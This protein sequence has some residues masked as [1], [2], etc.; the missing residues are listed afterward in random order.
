ML[1]TVVESSA[2]THTYSYSTN[3]LLFTKYCASDDDFTFSSFARLLNI[4]TVTI[5]IVLFARVS[6]IKRFQ[7]VFKHQPRKS[8]SKKYLR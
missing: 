1:Q 8:I 6:I 2:S 7:Q 3:D 4:V 5:I